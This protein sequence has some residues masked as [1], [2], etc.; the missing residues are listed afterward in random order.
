MRRPHSLASTLVLI[1]LLAGSLTSCQREVLTPQLMPASTLTSV[2]SPTGAPS[3]STTAVPTDTPTALPPVPPQVIE[4]TPARGAEQKSVA[5]IILTF[6]QPMNRTSVEI[7]F[8]IQPATEGVFQWPNARAMAFVPSGD[9]F[10]RGQRYK[11]TL[12]T[13]AQSESGLALQEQMQFTFQTLGFLEVAQTQPADGTID[14][15]LD[16]EVVVTFNRP[17]VPLTS[18]SQQTELPQPLIFTPQ[19]RGR[20]EWLNTAIYRFVPDNPLTPATTY[21]AWIASGLTDTTGG[22]LAEDYTWSF[23][24]LSPAVL[25]T[26]PDDNAMYVGPSQPI[27]VTFNQAVDTHLA[28]KALTLVSEDEEENTITGSITWRDEDTFAFTPG[29]PLE[30]ATQ[31]RAT[32]AAGIPS[33]TGQGRTE[34]DYVWRFSTAPPVAIRSTSPRDGEQRAEPWGRLEVRFAGPMDVWT[35][36]ANLTIIPKPTQ[37]YTYWEDYD[38]QVRLYF[39]TK[40]STDYSVTFGADSADRYGQSLGEPV[41][42]RFRT[43]ELDPMVHIQGMD[44][45]GFYNAYTDTIVYASYRNVTKLDF[46]LYRL[47]QTEF[48]SLIDPQSWELWRDYRPDIGNLV[49]RW[50]L[51]TESELNEIFNAITDVTD[52][53]GR[54][55]PGLYYLEL[56][57]LEVDS[58]ARQLLVLANT[59]LTLKAGQSEVLVWATDL[60]SGMT[61][62]S[63][64]VTIYGADR[65][66]LVTGNTDSD[67]T[68]YAT[69]AQRP[70]WDP[71]FAF[72]SGERE[73]FGV[74]MSQWNTGISPWEFDIPLQPELD[75]YRAS[76]YTDRSIYRP[77]QIVYW[78]GIVR[79]DD[80]AR[81]SLPVGLKPLTT[82]I[83]DPEGKPVWEEEV[84]LSE[85]GALHGTFLLDEE[86]STGH[87]YMTVDIGERTYST[88]F[89][90]AEYRKPE[91][92]VAVQTDQEEYIQGDSINV[93]SEALYYFGGPV[94][95]TG[96]RWALL[97]RDWRFSWD[98]DGRT[99][100]PSYEFS[101]YDWTEQ[102]SRRFFGEFGELMSEGSGRTDDGG[103]FTF[104]VPT[105]IA[106]RS[107]SQ[108]FTLEVTVTD[109]NHQSTSSRTES[110]VHKGEFYVGLAPREYVGTVGQEQGVDVIAISPQRH[111][112]PQQELQ[113]VVSEHRWYSVQRKGEGEGYYWDWEVEDVPVLTTTVTTDGEGRGLIRYTPQK[114]GTYKIL[115]IGQDQRGNKVQTSAYQW[116]S[117]GEFISWRRENHD[118]MEL[119]AD[120]KDYKPGDVAEVLVPSPFQGPVKALVT[121]ERGHIFQH[122]V[123]T[124]QT[125]SEILRIPITADYAPN[126]FLSVVL[127]KGI[128]ESSSKPS[129]RVG[130]AT[131]PVSTEQQE[132]SVEI[133]ADRETYQPGETVTYDIQT[134]DYTGQG[135]SAELSLALVDKAVLALGGEEQDSLLDVFYGQRGVS[136]QTSSSLVLFV[137]RIADQLVA[138]AKGGGGGAGM[139]GLTVRR[140][141]PDTAMWEPALTTDSE[142]QAQVSVELPD[143]LTTWRL[144]TIGITPETL[145]GEA[146]ADV[147]STKPLL[148]RPALPRFFVVGDQAQIGAVVHNNTDRDVDVKVSLTTAALSGTEGDHT[149]SLPARGKAS[150]TWSIA[151]DHV[152]EANLLFTAE[153]MTPSSSLRPLS[154]AVELSLPVYN[155]S[156]PEVVGTAGQLSEPGERVEVIHLPKQIDPSQGELA[157]TIEPSLAA[158]T[159]DGLR[160]LEH[161]PYECIEQVVSRWLPNLLTY[162]TL[163]ELAIERPDLEQGLRN[164]VPVGLQRVYAHQH[165]DGGWGWWLE[166]V[167]DPFLSAYVLLGLIEAQREDFTVDQ[168]A[169]DRATAFLQRNLSVLRDVEHPWEYNAQAFILYVLAERGDLAPS[170]AVILYETRDRLASYGKAFLALAL[171][172]ANPEERTRVDTLLGD[173]ANEV[174]LS[175][176]GA[177][178]EEE[179]DDIRTMNTDTRS[180]AIIVS[181]LSRLDPDSSMLPNAVRWLMVARKEGH[182]ETTQET[183]WALIGLTN[184]MAASG[185]LEADYSWR[186]LLNGE[187]LDRGDVNSSNLDQEKKQRVAMVDLLGEEGFRPSDGQ[188]LVIQRGKPVSGQTGRGQLYYTAHLRTFM[189]VEEVQATSRGVFVARQYILT[190]DERKVVDGAAINDTVQVKI[191]LVAPNDLHYLV[192][193]DPLPA[194]CEGI[195]RSLRTTSVV[196]ERPSLERVEE[197]EE[198]DGW[199]WWWFSHTDL[200]D[201][202]AVLF[203][204]H[205]PRGTYEYTYQIR[206]SVAGRF[207]VMPTTAYEMYFPEVWGRSDGGVFTVTE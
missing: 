18:L 186:A 160:Y 64:D 151:V 82:R 143:T 97:S 200:R 140:R 207:L 22:E 38:S 174:I 63:L 87:Y 21:G 152:D 52:T 137:E 198:R 91:F 34:S 102:R 193:E 56:K 84:P 19:V 127:V 142:G 133:R 172:L 17:V 176:T 157:V 141:F 39:T 145:V 107:I 125:N 179:R 8:D 138:K 105:D 165:P 119:I 166:D 42:V 109:V 199:G 93:T 185:E 33:A 167:S 122:K 131:L 6:D 78:K 170:R 128:D 153:Q 7:A 47:N 89:Q 116:V 60:S 155:Y 130:Y 44:R 76:L 81:Y 1:T 194:G 32:V 31:Y 103:R 132:L 95:D 159:R 197:G 100:C 73:T 204:T 104:H 156:T 51:P 10:T 148:L 206:A 134:T 96:V 191:T 162:R 147:I 192:V 86:A 80:D 28:E 12:D 37:V 67:G 177:H 9:G 164:L 27:T 154:D 4:H 46:A 182:W 74:A 41:V 23:T 99:P 20:G 135:V 66:E 58:Q 120:K 55:S 106:E 195:D 59:N 110:I 36:E 24:T 49:H 101:D 114:G 48:M 175:A 61:I 150:I 13:D 75:P 72:V 129:F 124:F 196:G 53:A 50:S 136:I 201:E 189:P 71:L 14:S 70:P 163:Q 161:Y 205:L 158:A 11:V 111:P 94:A 68:Y 181:A 5:P 25:S 144:T 171:D 90:V 3:P 43:R 77:G 85:N 188:R 178:W 173:L 54:L 35:V 112:V 183:A 180:T 169:I 121:I 15:R 69:F 30:R 62:P 98:C 57:A 184:Y 45:V 168:G 190:G 126:V 113:V 29:E 146:R 115:V 65:K 79:A 88:R 149:V 92:E 16:T 118:R 108:L 117:S 139:M 203:A 2:P 187:E 202:K 123:H 83:Q 40:P 26:I